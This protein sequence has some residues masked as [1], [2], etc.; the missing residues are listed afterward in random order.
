MQLIGSKIGI[1]LQAGTRSKWTSGYVDKSH[2]CRYTRT[3]SWQCD[4][5]S[6]FMVHHAHREIRIC[7]KTVTNFGGSQIIET[8]IYKIK[9]NCV[10]KVFSPVN[11]L[12]FLWDFFFL[13]SLIDSLTR[14]FQLKWDHSQT[15]HIPFWSGVNAIWRHRKTSSNP[16]TRV[17]RWPVANDDGSDC[18]RFAIA[19]NDDDDDNDEFVDCCW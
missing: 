7:Y 15:V 10:W 8:F 18:T 2:C 4:K 9:Y 17:I 11:W 16:P 13:L 14:R 5:K 3:T 6:I 12:N 19:D 1:R